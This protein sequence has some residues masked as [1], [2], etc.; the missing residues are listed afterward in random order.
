MTIIAK[1]QANSQ[2]NLKTNILHAYL[3]PSLHERHVSSHLFRKRGKRKISNFVSSHVT[4][5]IN[6]MDKF[7]AKKN[8]QKCFYVQQ[9]TIKWLFEF[10]KK[11]YIFRNVKEEKKF[12]KSVASVA[13]IVKLSIGLTWHAMDILGQNINVSIKFVLCV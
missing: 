12:N 1:I 8:S 11:F 5:M 9:T 10:K 4:Q 6:W 7:F 3:N 2:F 13:F